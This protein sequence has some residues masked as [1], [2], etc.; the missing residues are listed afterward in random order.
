MGHLT[1][2]EWPALLPLDTLGLAVRPGHVRGVQGEI[3]PVFWSEALFPLPYGVPGMGYWISNVSSSC[4]WE[5]DLLAT[6]T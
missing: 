5:P 3:G 1:V 6:A 2:L 4:F